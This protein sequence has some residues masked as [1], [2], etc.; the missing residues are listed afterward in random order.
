VEESFKLSKLIDLG[1]TEKKEKL[2]FAP[3]K[4]Y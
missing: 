4:K 3:S 1:P 2:L